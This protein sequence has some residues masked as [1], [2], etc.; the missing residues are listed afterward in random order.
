MIF[1]EKHHLKYLDRA[2]TAHFSFLATFF[3]LNVMSFDIWWSIGAFRGQVSSSSNQGRRKFLRYSLYAWG[4]PLV[5]G[6]AAAIADFSPTIINLA[7]KP[8]FGL[9]H[10]WF[11]GG[12]WAIF[13][14]FYGPV[15]GLLIANSVFFALTAKNLLQHRKETSD[16]QISNPNN[17]RRFSIYLKLFVVMGVTW[18]AEVLSWKI[19]PSSAWYIFD[20]INA[21]Q[22]SFIFFIFACKKRVFH[23]LKDRVLTICRGGVEGRRMPSASSSFSVR[24]G[25][26]VSSYVRKQS[27]E[28]ET[29]DA[30]I[31]SD[32]SGIP[33]IDRPEECASVMK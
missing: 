19:G 13:V 17:E 9:N 16:L 20:I 3:W 7:W 23:Q 18:L 32:R 14:Y 31:Q 26:T 10:C 29:I 4:G 2:I 28:L 30:K 5:L 12:R 11:A 6:T 21:L 25:R 8:R 24:T 1:A 15:A 27:L 22:G 33:T